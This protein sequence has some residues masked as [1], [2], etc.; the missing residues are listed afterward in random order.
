M[1]LMRTF[2]I[3]KLVTFIKIGIHSF[4]L[5]TIPNLKNKFTIVNSFFFLTYPILN[6]A[7]NFMKKKGNR[8]NGRNGHLKWH[9]GNYEKFHDFQF[10]LRPLF[11]NVH[12][13]NYSR[14]KF[15]KFYIKTV[16]FIIFPCT[17]VNNCPNIFDYH[18][19]IIICNVLFLYCTV[20]ARKCE[21][22]EVAFL[23]VFNVSPI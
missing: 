17:E 5:I 4:I 1:L 20:K 12:E 16:L 6:L 8:I 18:K 15:G 23:H 14:T 9:F 13:L 19:V 11:F 22:R 10:F 2:I 7:S 3:C 21:N